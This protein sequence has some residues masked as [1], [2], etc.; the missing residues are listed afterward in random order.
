[1]LVG[2]V[3]LGTALAGLRLALTPATALYLIIATLSGG[4]IFIALNL[5]TCVSAFWIMDSVPVTRAVFD[6]HLFVQYPLTIYPRAVSNLLTWVIPY[7]FA[8]FYP[9]SFLLGR[10]VGVLAWLGPV[11][12]VV[13]LLVGYRFWLFGLRHYSGTG[14]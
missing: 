7:G 12:A 6:N 13:L 14:S 2:L 3:L 1:L 5:L 10:D 9:A 4:L 11:V 8:S